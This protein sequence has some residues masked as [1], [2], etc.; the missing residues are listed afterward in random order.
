MAWFSAALMRINIDSASGPPRSRISVA[1]AGPSVSGLSKSIRTASKCALASRGRA[2]AADPPAWQ[3][4]P[5]RCVTSP[6]DARA[7]A[8]SSTTRTLSESRR[9]SA[10]PQA[11]ATFKSLAGMRKVRVVP[12]AMSGPKRLTGETSPKSIGLERRPR[13]TKSWITS[14]GAAR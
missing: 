8:N 6:S 13:K 10:R 4:G 9:S 5:G 1:H 7:S 3:T 12:V 14:V 2:L 11:V